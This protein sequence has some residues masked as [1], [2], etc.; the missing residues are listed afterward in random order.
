MRSVSGS[1]LA[2][3]FARTSSDAVSIQCRSSNS[4]ITGV[5][6]QR[7]RKRLCN[8][9]RVR[10][11]IRTPSRPFSAPSGALRPNRL[12][13]RP[14]FRGEWRS[15]PFS[16]SSRLRDTLVSASPAL[17][18]K[19]PRTTSMKTRKGVCCPSGEQL[20]VRMRTRLSA[21]CRRNSWSNRD[22]P[23]PGSPTTST[24]RRP[25]SIECKQRSSVS[26]SRLRPT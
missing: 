1:S 5:K 7:A 21:T 17:T 16:P 26:S 6:R 4:I 9:S 8:R 15:S 18:L 19:A 12:S 22:F 25:E 23:M 14:R 13:I 20:P 2:T 24:I 10:K 11:P 3:I